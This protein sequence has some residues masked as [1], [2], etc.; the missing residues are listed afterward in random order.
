M[1]TNPQDADLLKKPFGVLVPDKQVTKQKVASILSGAMRIIAVG[2][3][4]TDR[5]V[6]F[7]I[8]PDIAVIDGMERRSRRR[9]LADYAAK[10]L[11]CTNPAGRISKDAIRV[12]RGALKMSPPVRV[13]IDGE[14]DMLALPLFVMSPEGS[15]VLYGQPLEGLVVVTL[16][17]AK[18]KQAKDLMDRICDISNY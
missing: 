18:Q 12:L 14:E 15:I 9:N 4:T 16:T 7:G 17:P 3:A 2:D 6:N 13:L 8:T 11:R 5:L 1:P 10:E